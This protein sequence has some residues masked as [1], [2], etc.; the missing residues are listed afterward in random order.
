MGYLA[1]RKKHIRTD[2]I[3]KSLIVLLGLFSLIAFAENAPGQFFNQWRFQFYLLSLAVTLYA[4]AS[5]FFLYSFLALLLMLLNFF[6]VSS[7]VP[8]LFSGGSLPKTAPLSFVYQRQTSSLLDIFETAAG[9]RAAV[10]AV[11]NPLLGGSKAAELMPKDYHLAGNVENGSFMVTSEKPLG[12]GRINLGGHNTAAFAAIEIKGRK[13]VFLSLDLSR[14]T[15]AEREQALGYVNNFVASQDDP[16]IIFGDFGIPAW[17]PAF[18]R[19]LDSSGLEVKN[20]LFSLLRNVIFPPTWYITGY[21]NLEFD[22]SRRL[23]RRD[24]RFAPV[25]FRL[26]F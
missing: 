18:G 15:P 3:L 24:N 21:R 16:V 5:H 6:V 20:D 19:F 13:Y 10:L 7:S 23:P 4:L 14:Q 9:R 26:K 22:G 12:A 11:V 1:Q 17:A 25:L 8:V 2:F